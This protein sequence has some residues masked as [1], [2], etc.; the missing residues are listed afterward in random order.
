MLTP[1]NP[2]LLT[3]RMSRETRKPPISGKPPIHFKS[4]DKEYQE[5]KKLRA[6]R[7]AKFILEHFA[8]RMRYKVDQYKRKEFNER[9]ERE[10]NNLSELQIKSLNTVLKQDYRGHV[11]KEA[12]DVNQHL[13]SI[14]SKLIEA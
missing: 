3:K 7:D 8:K 11:L 5:L 12:K 2:L 1:H 6:K 14:Q 13:Y 9:I 4:L 10:G